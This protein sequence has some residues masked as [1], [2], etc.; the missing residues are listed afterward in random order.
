MHKIHFLGALAVLLMISTLVMAAPGIPHQFNGDVDFLDGPAPDGVLV[1]A[2]IN[3]ITV[4]S[5]ITQDGRYGYSSPT[6]KVEDPNG[7]RDGETIYFFVNGVDT[8]ET[9]IFENG[10]STELDLTVPES[11]PDIKT[12]PTTT[13][14][15]STTLTTRTIL[16]NCIL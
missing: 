6:F 11:I 14:S 9:A 16:T 3:G 4:E 7:D 8:G 5:G 10:E 2:K 13:T 15:T 1:E 12:I